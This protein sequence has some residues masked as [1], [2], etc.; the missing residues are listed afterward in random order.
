ML[1][2]SVMGY[3]YETFIFLVTAVPSLWL[4]NLALNLASVKYFTSCYP[5]ACDKGRIS[6]SKIKKRFQFL[7]FYVFFIVASSPQACYCNF[8]SR[9]N[10]E[11]VFCNI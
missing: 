11:L 1:N 10:D 3:E 6:S 4:L 8:T 7:Q 5:P 9:Y 2:I